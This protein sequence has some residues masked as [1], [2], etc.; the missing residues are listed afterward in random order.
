[1]LYRVRRDF[2]RMPFGKR[3]RVTGDVTSMTRLSDQIKR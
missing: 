1:M 2:R 3:S